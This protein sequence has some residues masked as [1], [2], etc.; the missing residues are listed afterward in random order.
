M[1]CGR[2]KR[3]YTSAREQI[4][5]AAEYVAIEQG[6]LQLTIDNIAK[7]AR[8]SKGGVL[9]HFPS[10]KDLVGAVLQRLSQ[11]LTGEFLAK[12]ELLPTGPGRFAKAA[13]AHMMGDDSEN[14][15]VRVGHVFVAAHIHFPDE[16]KK[17]ASNYQRILKMAETDGLPNEITAL[18]VATIDGLCM[19]ELF[20]IYR[21][22]KPFIAKMRLQLERMI[23][24]AV[25]T[26][27]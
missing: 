23:D 18:V 16:F 17:A 15:F 13:L 9:Y 7:H 26:H 8:L 3:E 22:E 21:Y 20:G 27:A 14:H 10:K 19:A 6:T 25:A 2:K 4:L 12:Y 5:D 11:K 24:H 1:F